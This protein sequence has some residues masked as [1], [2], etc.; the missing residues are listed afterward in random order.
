MA[1]FA[2]LAGSMAGIHLNSKEPGTLFGSSPEPAGE[3]LYRDFELGDVEQ[4]VIAKSKG[5]RASFI[6]REGVWQMVAPIKDRADYGVLQTIIYAARH[7]RVEDAYRNRS[8]TEN[9]TGMRSS[10]SNSGP[11]QITLRGTGNQTLADFTL[12]RR[13]AWHRLDDKD[14]HLSETFFVRP[15]ESS[16]DDH[17]YVC[18]SPKKLKYG[19]RRILDRGLNPLRD[20]HPLLIDQTRVVDI[21]IRSEGR[22]ILLS[23][24]PD[25]S[26]PWMMTKPLETRTKPEMVNGLIVGLSQLKA[27]RIHDQKSITIPPRPPGGFLLQLELSSKAAANDQSTASTILTVEPPNPP[28]ADTVFATS[29]ER[30]G[31]V[32][33]IP[34]N[35][36]TGGISLAQLPLKVDQ[37]RDRT[38]A[39]LDIGS[40][41][42]MTLHKVTRPDPFRV[43]LGR[44]SLGRPRWILNVSDEQSPANEAVVATALRALT[45]DEV[46]GFA[47]NAPSNLSRYG[48]S[49]PAKRMQ[50]ELEDGE[51]IDLLFGRSS[52]GRCYAMKQGSPTISEIRPSTYTAIASDPYQ[53]HDSLLMPFSVVDLSAMKI[54]QFPIRVP[55]SDPALTLKYKFLSE[56]WNARQHDQDVTSS[57]NKHRAN[58]FINFMEQLRVERWLKPD[59]PAA[60]RALL[61]PSFRLTAV[62]R[63]LDDEGEL[64][65]FRES[66][67]SLAPASSSPRNRIFYGKADGNPHYFVLG[68]DSYSTLKKSLLEISVP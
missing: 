26:S 60:V 24:D 3:F 14:G 10:T 20:H 44:D 42:S 8:I 22:E 2:V 33:E 62:F 51:E 34:R 4:L 31:L 5:E 52:D 68:A 35:P 1:L 43:F 23:R 58:Q 32:F 49:P 54:E 18:S 30:P 12:G 16:M 21:R 40:L 46:L 66:S 37:L 67:F 45:L 53:W 36:V 27:I 63:E 25:S 29:K 41:Q 59:T 65:G 13:S 55:L 9:E 47:S 57:L 17:V 64:R 6:K 38:L 7:L 48:L 19:I 50:L 28:E 56:E 39:D 11:Y 15:R 61:S